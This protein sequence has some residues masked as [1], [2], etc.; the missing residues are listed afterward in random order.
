[1][2]KQVLLLSLCVFLAGCEDMGWVEKPKY[3][4]LQQQLKQAQ[5]DLKKAQQQVTECQAHKYEVYSRGFRTF[6]LDTIT[7][8]TCILLT[9]PEDWKKAETNE[10]GCPCEDA[11][12]EAQPNYQAM[13]A[14]GCFGKVKGTN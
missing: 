13:S 2:R 8:K 3:D 6:R 14:M 1:M 4:A 11:M 12:N 10:Q 9:S 7:G 5:E